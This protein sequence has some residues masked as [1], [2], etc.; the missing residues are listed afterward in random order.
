MTAIPWGHGIEAIAAQ[1]ME[2]TPR[3]AKTVNATRDDA[4]NA[5]A[6][7]AALD[8]VADELCSSDN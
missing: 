2:D 1:L 4:E 3:P 8:A 6:S 5:A 7:E